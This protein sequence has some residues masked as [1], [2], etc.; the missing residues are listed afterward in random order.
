MVRLRLPILGILM[1]EEQAKSFVVLSCVAVHKQGSRRLYFRS[2]L[3]H[4]NSPHLGIHAI[5]TLP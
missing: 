2:D 5:S 3:Q 4:A 1:P